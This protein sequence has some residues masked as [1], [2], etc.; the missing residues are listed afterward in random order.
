MDKEL[1]FNKLNQ[2]L[3]FNGNSFHLTPVLSNVWEF[4][5]DIPFA[6]WIKSK[7]NLKRYI[8]IYK[9]IT[10]PLIFLKRYEMVM[11]DI[12]DKVK[13]LSEKTDYCTINRFIKYCDKHKL[14]V[15]LKYTYPYYLMKVCQWIRIDINKFDFYKCN[16]FIHYLT[17]FIHNRLASITLHI[18]R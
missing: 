4:H 15:N 12:N 3:K 18:Y 8:I 14:T 5:V 9:L 11:D 6:H 13:Y 10:S 16:R 17:F 7:K 1:F 2:F